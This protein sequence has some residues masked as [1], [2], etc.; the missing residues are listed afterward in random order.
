MNLQVANKLRRILLCGESGTGK[1]TFGLRYLVADKA[2]TCRFLFDPEGEF[3]ARLRL[4]AARTPDECAVAVEDSF[5]IYDPHEM[6]PG[7]LAAGLQWF[8]G[9]CFEAASAL[10]GEKMMLID[11]VWQYCSPNQIPKP[12]AVCIQT[13]RKRG[14]ATMFATQRPNRINEAITNGITELVAF[15]L[16]GDNALE[17][18]GEWVKTEEV[19]NLPDGAFVAVN[20]RTRGEMR[21]RLW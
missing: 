11:E 5:V 8:C 1:T 18:V 10:P 14:L 4:P 6:F 7:D 12:L 21:G 20:C 15:R 19:L 13:G 17:A 9:F 3:S 16:Q 2:L